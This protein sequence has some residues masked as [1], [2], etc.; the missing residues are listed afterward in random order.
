[1]TGAEISVTGVPLETTFDNNGTIFGIGSISFD[2]GRNSTRTLPI[3]K[4][5][6][7]HDQGFAIQRYEV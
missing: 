1:M 4:Q 6:L 5:D 2:I 3:P 7:M